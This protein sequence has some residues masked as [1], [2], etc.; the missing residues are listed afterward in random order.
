MQFTLK[1]CVATRNRKN[2]KNHYFGGSR[3][4]KV[5]D[6]DTPKNFVTSAC[7]HKHDVCAYLQLF[8]C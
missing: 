1:M 2:T 4:F 5:I 7:Y 6:V 3:L 8:S